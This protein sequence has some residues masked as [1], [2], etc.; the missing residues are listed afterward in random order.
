VI[1]EM[2]EAPMKAVHR[3]EVRDSNGHPDEAV[4]EIRHRRIRVLPPIGKQRRY[5]ALVLTEIRTEE[6]ATPKNR[7]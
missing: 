7:K 1:K 5:P 3:I 2:D 4:L 6:R